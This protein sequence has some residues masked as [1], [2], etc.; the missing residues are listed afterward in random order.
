V[1]IGAGVL[2]GLA[3]VLLA[4]Y[5][6]EK[7]IERSDRKRYPAPGRLV[8]VGGRRLHLF[9]QGDAAGPTVVIEQGTAS[10]SLVWWPV[11]AAI[12]KFARVCTYDRAGYLWS[13]PAASGRILEDRVA[14]LHA[15]LERAKVPGPYILVGHSL[16]GLLM[17]RFAQAHPKLVAGIVLVDA[18]NEAVMFRPAVARFYQ[19][20]LQMQKVMGVLARFGLVRAFARFMPMAMLPD[21]PMGYSLCVTPGH[22]AAAADEF[23]AMANVS[24]QMRSPEPPGSLGDRPLL[25]LTHGIPFPPMAAV[26]EEGWAEG[27]QELARL[28]TNSEVIVATKS[29][30]LV[31][32]DE[33]E[34][35][36]ESVRRVHAAARDGLP[37][38][39]RAM[40]AGA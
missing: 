9:S 13:D 11:Q 16:G 12:A 30:H 40:A 20:G 8:D 29:N 19:Q 14:D 31:H 21:D 25:L 22:A 35:V 27:M 7:L 15:L 36:I 10:P 38:V 1:S 2:V 3:A 34:L 28:S 33:P 24:E 5:V 4:A 23:Q 6:V 32:V 17:R 37:L 26:M 39:A 18:P